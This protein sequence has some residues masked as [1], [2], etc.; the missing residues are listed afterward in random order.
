[1]LLSLFRVSFSAWVQLIYGHFSAGPS[2]FPCLVLSEPRT[3]CKREKASRKIAGNRW[4]VREWTPKDAHLANSFGF[5]RQLGP[6]CLVS[7][8][9]WRKIDGN[10]TCAIGK[11]RVSA[12]GIANRTVRMSWF[13]SER[14][15]QYAA[16]GIE[17]KLRIILAHVSETGYFT[18]RITLF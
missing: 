4:V 17:E 12:S 5:T 16:V 2:A 18:W 3:E 15:N 1:M 9:A 7:L 10:V 13:L 11:S 6:G 8:S 14:T